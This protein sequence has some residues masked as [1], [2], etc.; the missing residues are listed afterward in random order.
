[1]KICIIDEFTDEFY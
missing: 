1:M